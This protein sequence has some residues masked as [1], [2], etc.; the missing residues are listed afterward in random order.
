MLGSERPQEDVHERWKA[1]PKDHIRV[2]TLI[3]GQRCWCWDARLRTMP[4]R[5]KVL[6]V[7]V[8][9][10]AGGAAADA[11]TP[12]SPPASHTTIRTWMRRT[13]EVG[14]LRV[15]FRQVGHRVVVSDGRGGTLTAAIGVRSITADGHGQ[16]VF[17][18]HGQHFLGWDSNREINSIQ[19]ITAVGPRRLDVTYVRYAP[20]DPLCCPSLSPLAAPARRKSIRPCARTGAPMPTMSCAP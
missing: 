14:N 19:D 16:L 20:D 18:F 12:S 8:V 3:S 7:V 9:L 15:H 1:G 17:F 4:I 11:A 10:M 2:R 5:L 6:A 13:V